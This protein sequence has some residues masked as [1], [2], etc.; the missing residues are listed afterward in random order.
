MAERTIKSCP[1][2]QS[3][4]SPARQ[5]PSSG[6]FFFQPALFCVV[7][8][9]EPF[10]FSDILDDT[11]VHDTDVKGTPAAEPPHPPLAAH[12][13]H[14]ALRNPRS[15]P[16]VSLGGCS[17]GGAG[18]WPGNPQGG[19]AWGRI[20]VCVF[21]QGGLARPGAREPEAGPGATALCWGGCGGEAGG[22]R[23]PQPVLVRVCR[24]DL[25]G[26]GVK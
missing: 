13:L 25:H 15:C 26:E 12:S 14:A 11:F 24:P 6:F 16:S 17:R 2:H 19:P 10:C 9:T 4:K 1:S 20:G 21:S 8:G 3:R 23:S 7:L 5:F 22:L 18:W